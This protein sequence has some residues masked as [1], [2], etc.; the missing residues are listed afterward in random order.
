[1]SEA[2]AAACRKL[3]GRA[4]PI[5]VADRVCTL[6][7]ATSAIA[8]DPSW[9]VMGFECLGA[10]GRLALDRR[11]EALLVQEEGAAQ[12]P[13][14]LRAVL[15]ADALDGSRRV[16]EERTG[17]Q[18]RWLA[19]PGA[20][21][22][23]EPIWFD[24]QP[25]GPAPGQA[26]KVALTFDDL[27]T[28]GRISAAFDALPA[29][30]PGRRSGM[31]PQRDWNLPLRMEVGSTRLTWADLSQIAQGDI[32]AVDRWESRGAGLGVTLSAGSATRRHWRAHVEHARVTIIDIEKDDMQANPT[33][34]AASSA[35]PGQPVTATPGEQR[36]DHIMLD[37]IGRLDVDIRFEVAGL[38]IRLDAL[39]AIGPGY[40]FDL[41]QALTQCEVDIVCHANL[42][43]KGQLVA[44]GERLGVRVTSF[45]AGHHVE[46]A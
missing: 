29:P 33:S 18:A 27:D 44:V 28:W 25:P 17:L 31:S 5:V 37:L 46:P 43:G 32:V 20:S 12:L 41:P 19:V 45:A 34:P 21:D 8:V 2:C 38:S 23:I 9:L 10:S 16:F 39:A 42:L 3:A 11:G 4:W 30:T 24:L 14:A 36:R 26:G 6:E 22:G 15:L 7:L 35:G 13:P 1:M 40:V